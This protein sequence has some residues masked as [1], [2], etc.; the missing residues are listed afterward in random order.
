ML[1]ILS[2]DPGI[3]NLGWCLARGL[4]RGAMGVV[5]HGCEDCTKTIPGCAPPRSRELWDR[6]THVY[7]HRLRDHAE[8][9]DVILCERQPIGGLSEVV[10]YF[11]SKHP[12]KLERVH[13]RS[14][15][16]FYNIQAYDYDGRKRCTQTIAKNFIPELCCGSLGPGR[17]AHDVADAV[18]QAWFWLSTR[19]HTPPTERVVVHDWD[20]F[21]FKGFSRET[22]KKE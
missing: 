6:L 1:R 19:P 11:Y 12:D 4:P 22:G 9:A 16:C 17:R 2:I 7:E 15:H 5:A 13:P 10:S 3:V 14:M 20:R 21:A 18:A 8:A